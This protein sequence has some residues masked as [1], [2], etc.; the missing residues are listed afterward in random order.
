M[1]LHIDYQMHR[2]T[3]FCELVS[4]PGKVHRQIS[5]K[6][7]DVMRLSD[8]MDEG[9]GHQQPDG[10]SEALSWPTDLTVL[11]A[12]LLV[13]EAWSAFTLMFCYQGLQH[14]SL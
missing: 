13:H 6:I 10:L 7:L 11:S 4:S 8:K 2:I 12:H 9:V 14:L 3:R 1:R 5:S